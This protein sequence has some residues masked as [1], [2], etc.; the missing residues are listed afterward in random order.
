MKNT[1]QRGHIC[2]C[3]FF[4]AFFAYGQN[5]KTI[6]IDVRNSRQTNLSE[7]TEKIIP[8]VLERAVSVQNGNIFLTNDFL[9]LTSPTSIAQYDWTGKFIRSINCEGYITDN[10]TGDTIKRELYVPVGDIIKCFDYSGKLKKSYQLKNK[11]LHILYYKDY[12]WVQTYNEQSDDKYQHFIRKI[13]LSTGETSPLDFSFDFHS[14]D[15]GR[16]TLYKGELV[17]SFSYDNTLYKIQ[18]DKVIPIVKWNIIPFSDSMRDRTTLRA[19]GY[20]G[21]YLFINYRRGEVLYTYLENMKT[22]KKINISNVVDD[23]FN[24]NGHC[25]LNPLNKDGYFFFIK[26]NNE[27]KGNSIGNIPLKNGPVLFIVKTK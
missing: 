14:T 21:E 5:T 4:Y 24:T 12:L 16:I 19:N 27:I 2:C 20:N 17:I 6:N 11:T 15:I 25:Q 9:F 3:L 7:I 10:V 26:D 13:N 23:V 1:F 22:G 18:Q 8:V